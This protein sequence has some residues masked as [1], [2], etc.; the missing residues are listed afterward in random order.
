MTAPPAGYQTPSPNQPYG[1]GP[2]K[3]TYKATKPE[4]IPVANSK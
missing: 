3:D 4:D 1:L 2:A